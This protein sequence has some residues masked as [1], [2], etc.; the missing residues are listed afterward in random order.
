MKNCNQEVKEKSVW[1]N[2]G[3]FNI[4]LFYNQTYTAMY[5]QIVQNKY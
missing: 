1:H 3:L 2:K 5:L 4:K